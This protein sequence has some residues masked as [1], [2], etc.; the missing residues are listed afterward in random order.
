MHY[1]DNIADYFLCFHVLEHI[2]KDAHAL[3]EIRRVLKPGGM[4]VLQVPIDWNVEK[5]F[6]YSCAEPR[7]VGH[8]RRYGRDF[9]QRISL[10][11]FEVSEVSVTEF[12]TESEIE[13]FGLSKEPI[14][15][16]TK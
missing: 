8:V 13:R 2:E 11:G 10:S 14:F 15:F 16:A 9:T 5:T 7:D 3:E 4:A 1:Q 12:L 6:E